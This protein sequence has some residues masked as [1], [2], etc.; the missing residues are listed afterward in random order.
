MIPTSVLI[1]PYV[2]SGLITDVEGDEINKRVL[3]YLSS[4]STEV[5]VSYLHRLISSEIDK[6]KSELRKI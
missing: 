1:L 3:H 2:V 6:Y 4:M 5:T